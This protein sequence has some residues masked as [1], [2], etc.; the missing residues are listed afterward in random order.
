MTAIPPQ[1][2]SQSHPARGSPP[3][4]G[5]LPERYALPSVFAIPA[6][7]PDINTRLGIAGRAKPPG[8]SRPACQVLRGRRCWR[9]E[10]A[11]PRGFS[12]L[13]ALEHPMRERDAEGGVDVGCRAGIAKT[14]R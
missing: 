7:D 13:S 8:R 12:S 1:A 11:D 2:L 10:H 5:R 14:L 9:P 6:G 4:A 3:T